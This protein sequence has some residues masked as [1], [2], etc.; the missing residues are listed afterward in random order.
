[1]G[2]SRVTRRYAKGLFDYVSEIRKGD[3]VFA[4]MKN[5]TFLIS[6]SYDLQ[7]FLRTPLLSPK[8]KM[9]ISKEIFKSFS[10]IFQGFIELLIFHKREALLGLISLEYQK[11]YQVAQGIVEAVVTTAIPLDEFLQKQIVN[12]IIYILGP[13]KKYKLINEIDPVVIGGFLL[14]VGDKQWDA[15]IIGKFDQLRKKLLDYDYIKYY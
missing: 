14:R 4:D 12:K 8:R 5:L 2:I 10:D 13:D 3:A 1:M 15:T 7:L 9:K 11:M 6:E